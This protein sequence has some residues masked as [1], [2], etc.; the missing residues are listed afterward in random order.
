M[1]PAPSEDP[2]QVAARKAAASAAAAAFAM[3]AGRVAETS[4]D[5]A[6]DAATAKAAAPQLQPDPNDRRPVGFEEGHGRSWH[7]D[8]L[9]PAMKPPVKLWLPEPTVQEQMPPACH[10]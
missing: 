8:P 10:V 7:P 9:N 2:A 3:A 5:A 4:R 6:R 1:V